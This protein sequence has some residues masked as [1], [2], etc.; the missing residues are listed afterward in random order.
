ML[1]LMTSVEAPDIETFTSVN[2]YRTLGLGYVAMQN[3]GG[4][5]LDVSE[6]GAA[7]IDQDPTI[8]PLLDRMGDF[9]ARHHMYKATTAV[10]DR[11]PGDILKVSESLRASIAWGREEQR[12]VSV[13]HPDAAPGVIVKAYDYHRRSAG[14]QFY[15]GDWMQSKLDRA[16]RGVSSAAQLAILHAPGIR[17]HR[18]VVMEHIPGA[19]LAG[20]LRSYRDKDALPVAREA[21]DE[22]SAIVEHKVH[23]ALGWRGKLIANDVL[24]RGNIIV[25]E[26]ES[27]TA[28]NLAD[29]HLTVIDQPAARRYSMPGLMLARHLPV[30]LETGMPRKSGAARESVALSK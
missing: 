11:E 14:L 21:A 24:N 6:V 10:P 26:P 5:R 28:D 30:A 18:T 9:I 2:S 1:L 22:A 16:D 7:R 3:D 17:G 23:R 25:D 12:L 27:V 13:Y 8:A 19:S 15:L 4:V 20:W 29:Q